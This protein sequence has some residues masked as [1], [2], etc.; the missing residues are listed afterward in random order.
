[1]TRTSKCRCGPVECPV[2]SHCA[3][4]LPALNLLTDR[5]VDCREMAVAAR[6]TPA[7][8]DHDV[9]SVAAVPLCKNNGSGRGRRDGRAHWRRDI[10]AGVEVRRP[11]ERVGAPAEGRGDRARAPAMKSSRAPLRSEWDS[12]RCLPP[13]VR[14]RAEPRAHAR[15]LE[16]AVRAR[17]LPRRKGLQF[18]QLRPRHGGVARSPRQEIVP[19]LRERAE[20]IARLLLFFFFALQVEPCALQVG[21]T[22]ATL[23]SASFRSRTAPSFVPISSRKS[24]HRSTNSVKVRAESRTAAYPISP[25][26]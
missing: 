19:L 9:I 3:D 5:N 26:S 1:M 12:Q 8:V 24:S 21:L 17:P 13:A 7:V 11:S 20:L 4:R 2:R 10:Q 23:L 14:P 22:T 16:S 25:F 6:D 15:V 18:P